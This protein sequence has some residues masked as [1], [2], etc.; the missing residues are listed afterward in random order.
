MKAANAMG[1]KTARACDGC[2]RKR[3]R[4]YCVA[5][6]AF[7]CQACDSSVHSA[8]QLASRHERVR[9]ET[10]SSKA[11]NGRLNNVKDGIPVWHQGFTRKARTPRPNKAML[12]HQQAQDHE[13]KVFNSNDP[14]VPEL[15]SEEGSLDH[16]ENVEESLLCQ[17]PVFNP[18]QV[19]ISSDM[20]ASEEIGMVNKEENIVVDDHGYGQEGTCDLDDLHRFLPSDMDLAEFAADVESLLGGSTGLDEDS[21]DIKGLDFLDCKEENDTNVCF[22]DTIVKVKD[23]DD[24]HQEGVTGNFHLEPSYSMTRE[25]MEWSFDYDDS[26]LVGQDEDEKVVPLVDTAMATSTT[27]QCKVERNVSLRLNYE[28]VINAW[29]SQ[30]C[31][32]TTGSRP[33][34]NPDDCWPNCSVSI[35]YLSELFF[36]N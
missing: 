31:P 8:N 36:K 14:L 27:S 15:G 23:E 1:G 4:W 18:F 24:H 17:V 19:E 34:F 20:I 13:K 10:A 28:A 2:L 30:G 7:L 3:A 32:W 9:L 5:D 22:G 11:L 33:E 21:S 16:D 26:P 29:A 6:D 35:L 25:A 12:A